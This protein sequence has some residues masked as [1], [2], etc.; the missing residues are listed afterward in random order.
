[1]RNLPSYR[2][3][4]QPAYGWAKIVGMPQAGDII[5]INGDPYAFGVD[6]VGQS[7]SQ[8][9]RSLVEAIRADQNDQSSVNPAN[10]GFFRAYDAFFSGAYCVIYATA[11]G[12]AGNAIT[13]VSNSARITVSGGTLANGTDGATPVVVTPAGGALT[14]AAART[15]TVGGTSQTVFAANAARRYLIIQNLSA[16][17]L[18]VNFGAAATAGSPS[19]GLAPA[20][21]AIPGGTVIFEGSY[22]PTSSVTIIGATTGDSFSAKQA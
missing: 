20:D 3:N 4:G 9:L 22:I 18:F 6:F 15:I 21:G 10:T 2:P 8:C 17:E 13:L 7:P 16:D 19:I 1:M 14:D 12:T 11:P 5:T